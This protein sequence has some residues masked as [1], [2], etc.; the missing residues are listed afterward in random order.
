MK[1]KKYK[2]THTE[3][4]ED[5]TKTLNNKICNCQ[6]LNEERDRNRVRKELLIMLTN[7][8]LIIKI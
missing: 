4:Y 1:I 2:I 5:I 3:L 8:Y 6:A 7:N